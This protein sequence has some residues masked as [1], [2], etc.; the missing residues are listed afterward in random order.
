MKSR[1]SIIEVERN[2]AER[3][4]RKS[5]TD[6]CKRP[7]KPPSTRLIYLLLLRNRFKRPCL[8]GDEVLRVRLSVMIGNIDRR[9]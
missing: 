1:S 7:F 6:T 4:S 8:E 3:R 2:L 5:S 9:I